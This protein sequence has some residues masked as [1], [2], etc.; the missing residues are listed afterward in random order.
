[1]DFQNA[2]IRERMVLFSFDTGKSKGLPVR[3][4]MVHIQFQLF[5]SPGLSRMKSL[6]VVDKRE[7][8][9]RYGTTQGIRRSLKKKH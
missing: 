3:F 5:I 8:K 4:A 1:L 9:R 6:A 2:Q 7:K